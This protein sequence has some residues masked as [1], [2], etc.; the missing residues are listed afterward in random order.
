MMSSLFRS[1]TFLGTS[2]GTP[3]TFR[4]VSSYCL[5]FSDGSVWLVDAGEGTQ[6]QLLRCGNVS[7]GRIEKIFLTHLHGD[8]C[9]GLPGLMCSIGMLWSPPGLNPEAVK[10]RLAMKQSSSSGAPAEEEAEDEDDIDAPHVYDHFSAKS[11]YLE[12]YGPKGTAEM[13]RAVLLMSEARFGFQFRVNEIVEGAEAGE[14]KPSSSAKSLLIRSAHG[15][16]HPDEVE[17]RVITPDRQGHYTLPVEGSLTVRAA[18]LNHRVFT[19][20]YVVQEADTPGTLDMNKATQLGVPKGP[21]LAKLKAGQRVAFPGPQGEEVTV[22]PEDVVGPKVTGRCI[23]L[24]GDTCDS[25]NIATMLNGM[26]VEWVV[27]ESTFDG[28][29][30]KLAIPRGHSTAKMAGA[31]GS[32]IGAKNIILTH[33]SARFA[34]SAKDPE[35]LEKIRSEAQAVCH[36]GVVHIADD[37]TVFDLER[38]KDKK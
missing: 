10:V 11:Q 4:N 22:E 30:E 32:L 31:F 8:H 27:H 26:P 2:S 16:R 17:P 35:A 6:H 25:C 34:S 23:V 29:N 13:L 15:L 38:K 3:T 37:F 19:V 1:L 7:R 12:I 18:T 9:Y 20:G 36:S 28:D 24:L 14:C 33:F 21:L 5:S